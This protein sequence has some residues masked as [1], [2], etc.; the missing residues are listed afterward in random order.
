MRM[1]W[2]LRFSGR[3]IATRAIA[4]SAQTRTPSWL[5]GSSGVMGTWCKLAPRPCR[6]WP[7]SR[8]RLTARG[9]CGDRLAQVSLEEHEDPSPRVLGGGVVMVEAGER[10]DLAEER[11]GVD[12]VHE[13]VTGVGIFLDVVVDAELGERALQARGAIAQRPVT[14][15]VAADDRAHADEACRGVLGHLAVVDRR[16]VEVAPRRAE[17]REPAAHAEADDPD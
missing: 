4:P 5:R 17:K 2:A 11:A 15:A 7:A 10:D 6:A 13:A 8:R 12:A 1:S 3:A 16:G 14:P 9:R